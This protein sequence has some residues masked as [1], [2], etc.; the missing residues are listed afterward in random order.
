MSMPT[1]TAGSAAAL[2]P[3]RRE[4]CKT[5]GGCRGGKQRDTFSVR[6]CLFFD[7]TANNRENVSARIAE[8][9]KYKDHAGE[10]SYESDFSNI[11][12]LEKNWDDQFAATLA[13]IVFSIYIEGIGTTNQKSDHIRGMALGEGATGV[14]AKVKKGI[15]HIVS[16]INSSRKGKNIEYIHLDVYGFSRG[17]AAARHFVYAALID[18]EIRLRAK[19]E[20]LEYTIV[21]RIQVKFVGLFDTVASY[22]IDHSNDTA[23]LHL[24]ML[25]AAEKVIQLAAADEHRVNFPLTNIDSAANGSQIFLPGGHSDI[26]GGYTAKPVEIDWHILCYEKP[27]GTLMK[28]TGEAHRLAWEQ[29]RLIDS[30]WYR[31]TEIRQWE[32][33]A[34]V[35]YEYHLIVTRPHI[36]NQYSNIPLQIMAKRSADYGVEFKSE[37]ATLYPIPA[38]LFDVKAIIDD[39]VAQHLSGN[40]VSQASD[41]IDKMDETQKRLRHD[42]LH[43]TACYHFDLVDS[44]KPRF[45]DEY[46]VTPVRE[47]EIFDG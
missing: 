12:K 1:G 42:Y 39:Y 34:G 4:P 26:G 32:G 40:A 13:D 35:Q 43:F 47:R 29:H 3:Q 38:G 44:N 41:W 8:T 7:G 14:K 18:P 24:N 10:R 5:F 23:D 28:D 21:G 36:S 33:L 15:D 19:L 11:H 17:A 31:K 25:G 37:L 16:N 9:E 27:L 45:K 46:S 6:A 30:G 20:K 22:G 2:N